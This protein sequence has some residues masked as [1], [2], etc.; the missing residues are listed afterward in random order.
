[1]PSAAGLFHRASVQSGGG[2]NIP[3]GE[4]SKEV[5]ETDDEGTWPAP[6]DMAALQ[7]MEWSKL[8]AAG[9]A[10]VAKINPPLRGLGGPGRASRTPRVGW[11]PTVDGRIV[12][13]AVVLRRRSGVSK[14][15]PMLIGSVSEEG[16]HYSSNPTE[17]EW[18]ATLASSA[19]AKPR[20]AR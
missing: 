20:Q 13:R 18:H 11:S 1:M 15:V 10:A 12:T 8:I 16:M 19:M 14:N 7:K 4:Q 5:R 6:N 3:S 2:G 17:E 9:N